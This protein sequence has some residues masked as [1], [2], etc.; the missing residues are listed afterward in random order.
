MAA[1]ILN[2]SESNL[3]QV[4]KR[5]SSGGCLGLQRQWLPGNGRVEVTWWVS[6]DDACELGGGSWPSPKQT[7]MDVLVTCT[8]GR[9][10]P[11][12]VGAWTGAGLPLASVS[13]GL[14]SFVRPSL[15]PLRKPRDFL[16]VITQ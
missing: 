15:F 3:T 16:T 1:S 6:W 13:W 9:P 14:S 2:L 11:Q 8:Q 12:A 7:P 4:K 5:N 10:H